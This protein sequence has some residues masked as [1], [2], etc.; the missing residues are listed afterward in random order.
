MTS[1]E[2]AAERSLPGNRFTPRASVRVQLFGAAIVWAVGASIL[3]IRGF[4]YVQGRYWHA[5]VLGAALAIAVLKSRL[6]LDRVARR[7]VARIQQRGRACFFGFFSIKAWA[8]VALMMGGG[9]TLRHLIVH[10]NMIGAGI[11][12]ALYIGIGTALAV[13]D[14]IFWQAALGRPLPA[15][16]PAETR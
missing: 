12:G 2:I 11:L 7:A 14:R 16:E 5:W 15:E 10:P 3:I 1:S 6:L 9:I 8:F 4:G 13:A